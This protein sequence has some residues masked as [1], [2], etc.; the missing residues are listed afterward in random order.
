MSILA[1][2]T[3]V[4]NCSIT[5]W[6]TRSGTPRREEASRWR[7]GRNGGGGAELTVRDTGPGIDPE[8]REHIFEPFY[9]GQIQKSI[10]GTGLGL[11]IVKRIAEGH[12]GKMEVKTRW[13]GVRVQGRP[14]A[15]GTKA[16]DG[17][18]HAAES[19]GGAAESAGG[20]RR[21]RLVTGNG[22]V[23]A[24]MVVGGGIAGMQAA[25]DLAKA[26][27]KVYLVEEGTAIGGAMAQ[28]DKTF[29]T[30]DCAMC[31]L[32]PKLVELGRHKDVELLT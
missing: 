3:A 2:P 27:F 25:L 12:G 22:K 18:A 16:A 8:E 9:R 23:G 11:P 14:S 19:R 7:R 28:L 20:E 29:P 4:E 24:V 13:A 10:P 5:S 31:T 6:T 17:F 32:A 26:G 1:D 15:R 21:V 30:N